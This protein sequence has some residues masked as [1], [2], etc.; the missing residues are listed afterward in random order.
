MGT[1]VHYS[2]GRPD[3][4]KSAVFEY[5]HELFVWLSRLDKEYPG[6]YDSSVISKAREL[7]EIGDSALEVS[8]EN[9][10]Y[11]IDRVVVELID[12]EEMENASK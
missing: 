11:L 12:F 8:S 6:E 7:A 10:A 9:E 1:Y 3:G 2:L 5:A 4:I